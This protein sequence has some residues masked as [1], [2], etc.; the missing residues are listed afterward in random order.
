MRTC[1][2]IAACL[3]VALCG[4]NAVLGNHPVEPS[5]SQPVEAEAGRGGSASRGG[6]GWASAA[7]RGGS[8]AANGG[9]RAGG[10]EGD[11]PLA[12]V[13]GSSGSGGDAGASAPGA[14]EPACSGDM[15]VCEQ[16]QCVAC[17]S[18]SRD[19]RGGRPRTCE[20]GQ[21]VE[22]AA[23][24]GDTPLCTAG[25]CGRLGVTASFVSI[26]HAVSS[27]APLRLVEQD[28]GERPAACAGDL[29]L[30]GRFAATRD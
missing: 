9:G 8:A 24:G 11:R 2:W 20:A 1:T 17:R 7:G 6:L 19:C 22:L 23:C 21:W 14:C 13:G 26:G 5:E 4:C 27:D 18:D 30:T 25:Q 12:A 29:C 10:G 3:G 28:F 15:P 16:A